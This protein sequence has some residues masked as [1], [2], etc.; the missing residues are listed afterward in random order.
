MIRGITEEQLNTLVKASAKHLMYA[1]DVPL[2]R[3]IVE[4]IESLAH[5]VTDET[6]VF[7]N[8]LESP[9]I[10]TADRDKLREIVADEWQYR[11]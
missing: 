5:Y 11:R 2:C 8:N 1:Q 7:L 4:T 9:K 6:L 10:N 3:E